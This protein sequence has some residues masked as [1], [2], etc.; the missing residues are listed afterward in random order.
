M[1]QTQTC[2]PSERTLITPL[3]REV[4]MAGDEDDMVNRRKHT[5]RSTWCA[6]RMG[7]D[8][9]A[10]KIFYDRLFEQYP[11][12]RP[13]FQDDM[14]IQYNKLFHAVSLAVDCLDK[15]DELIPVLQTLGRA[16]AG[17][18]TVRAHYEAVTECFIWTL[19]SYILAQMP[20]ANVMNWLL[21]IADAWE[22]VLTLIG[23]IMAAAGDDVIEERRQ[24]ILAERESSARQQELS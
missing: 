16:H 17:F 7:L 6:V 11:V 23:G 4:D 20:N 12:V 13:L 2:F 18:G 19:N 1:D 15:L 8:V 10:T 5:I 14:T 24:K 22:W 21:E 9:K 3:N